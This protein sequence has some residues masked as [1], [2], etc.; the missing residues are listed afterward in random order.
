MIIQFKKKLLFFIKMCV[1]FKVKERKKKKEGKD[2][3][4][5]KGE[6]MKTEK[7]N[8]ASPAVSRFHSPD[9]IKM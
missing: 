5:Q 6:I 3:E 8:K 1:L 7:K 2:A 9:N 4:T